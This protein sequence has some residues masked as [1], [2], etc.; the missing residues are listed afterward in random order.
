MA[1]YLDNYDYREV[2]DDSK[3]GLSR[4]YEYVEK[5]NPVSLDEN[6]LKFRV[7]TLF[8]GMVTT[9]ATVFP[10]A[11]RL[12]LNSYYN[13]NTLNKELLNSYKG[14]SFTQAGLIFD[15]YIV[16]YFRKTVVLTDTDSALFFLNTNYKINENNETENI[17]TSVITSREPSAILSD[18]DSG[19]YEFSSWSGVNASVELY[20][21]FFRI[22]G[23]TNGNNYGIYVPYKASITKK[24]GSYS[25]SIIS[26]PDSS[27]FIFSYFNLSAPSGIGGSYWYNPDNRDVP[28]ITSSSGSKTDAIPL[29]LDSAQNSYNSNAPS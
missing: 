4:S 2:I 5:Y 22:I 28:G 8:S 25:Y 21:N 17:S 16:P 9:A 10:Y 15:F 19:Y 14:E 1:D 27:K 6:L 13:D 29:I 26:I 23:Y 20:N 11:F 18:P 24:S 7:P 3:Y 12:V